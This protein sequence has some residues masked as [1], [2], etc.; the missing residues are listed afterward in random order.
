MEGG[1]E[2]EPGGRIRRTGF[3]ELKKG[4]KVLKG[5]DYD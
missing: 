2:K 3:G 1:R 4:E 5:K